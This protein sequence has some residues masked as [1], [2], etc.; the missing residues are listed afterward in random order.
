MRC[1]MFYID[2]YNGEYESWDQHS[3]LASYR[4]LSI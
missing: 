2:Y 3:G 4:V 1:Q